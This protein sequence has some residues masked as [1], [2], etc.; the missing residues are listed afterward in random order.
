MATG[1][2]RKCE[3]C[4]VAYTPHPAAR[5]PMFCS[6]P[7][8]MKHWRAANAA[9]V[10]EYQK[11]YRNDPENR[12]RAKELASGRWLRPERKEAHSMWVKKHRPVVGE[13]QRRWRKGRLLARISNPVWREVRETM[14]LLRS[15]Q[16]RNP[17]K[18]RIWNA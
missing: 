18:F 9:A 14:W 5:R 16:K 17:G 1:R 8:A 13:R 3:Q 11:A 10:R 4:G 7:C 15:W 12:A 6:K 2:S